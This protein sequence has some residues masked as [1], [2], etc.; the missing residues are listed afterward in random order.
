LKQQERGVSD[1]PP[2]VLFEKEDQLY[3]IGL[4]EEKKDV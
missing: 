4:A 1:I 2:T 3:R